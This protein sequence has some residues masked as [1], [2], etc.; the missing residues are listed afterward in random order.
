MLEGDASISLEEIHTVG[1][2]RDLGWRGG[3]PEE[4]SF[5]S[6]VFNI[7]LAFYPI[8]KRNLSMH[9]VITGLNYSHW[10]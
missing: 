1:F 8:I 4:R 9:F 5:S 10:E 2:G 3:Y 7:F 6:F